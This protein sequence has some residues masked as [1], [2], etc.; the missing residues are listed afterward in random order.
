MS[1]ERFDRTASL[2]TNVT[3]ATA[4]SVT[5]LQPDA[6]RADALEIVE[7]ESWMFRETADLVLDGWEP[8]NEVL[9]NTV[10]ENAV[11][12]ARSLCEIFVGPAKP[13]TITLKVLFSDL[14]RNRDRYVKLRDAKKKLKDAYTYR[15][16]FNTRVMHPT[17]LRGRYGLYE[18]PLRTLRPKILAVVREIAALKKELHFR[19]CEVRVP[20]SAC[21]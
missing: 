1:G 10:V 3:S 8:P 7:Y 13:D 12:H 2:A 6:L 19:A 18:E 20:Y 4:L 17:V 16:L 14:D 11:L 9:R 15:T 21:R 5:A